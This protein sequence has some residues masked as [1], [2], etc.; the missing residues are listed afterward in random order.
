MPGSLTRGF[1]WISAAGENVPGVCVTLNFTY[2]VRGPCM[3]AQSWLCRAYGAQ[4]W[5]EQT[6]PWSQFSRV[7]VGPTSG[8]SQL[9]DILQ[10]GFIMGPVLRFQQ[11][12]RKWR[13]TLHALVR[14]SLRLYAIGQDN[15]ESKYDLRQETSPGLLSCPNGVYRLAAV[16]LLLTWYPITE[17]ILCVR[18]AS[19]W[20]RYTVTPSLIGWA[21]SQNDPCYHVINSPQLIWRVTVTGHKDRASG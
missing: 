4:H 9:G 1:L 19:E 5:H 14:T 20:R 12:L 8:Q 2:L 15:A 6:L 3:L 10:Q 7:H 21:H 16:V 11:D 13:K 18:P 17:I